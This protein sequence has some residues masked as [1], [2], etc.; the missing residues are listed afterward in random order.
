MKC[1]C[2][3]QVHHS[4]LHVKPA[5]VLQRKITAHGKNI[6]PT[7]CANPTCLKWTLQTALQSQLNTGSAVTLRTE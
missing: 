7:G 5:S 2:N 4:I 6:Y 3:K 1:S